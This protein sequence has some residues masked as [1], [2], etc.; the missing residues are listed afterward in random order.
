MQ[1]LL[2]HSKKTFLLAYPVVLSQLGHILVG[3][4]DSAMVG[5]LG[6]APLAAVSLGNSLFSIVL[7]MGIGLS[8]GLTPLV[9]AA[10]GRKDVAENGRLLRHGNVLLTGAGLVLCGLLWFAVPG[11]HF[12]RQPEAV[13][14][15]TIPYLRVLLFS[16]I[17]LMAF[18]ALRQF[19]EG[20]SFTRQAMYISVSANLVNILGNWLLINGHWGLPALG[21][22]GAGLSTLFSR[23]LMALGMAVYI[24]YSRRFAPYRQHQHWSRFSGPVFR[25]IL[26]LGIPISL[27]MVFEISAFSVA[28]LMVGWLGTYELAAHQ[29]AISLAAVTYMM[30]SGISTAATI[31]VGNQW[32]LRNGPEL[33]GVGLSAF[34]MVILF[35]ASMAAV[36][37]LGRDVLTSLYTPDRQVVDIAVQLLIIAA[38]FQLSDGVQVVALG[39]LRGMSDV[40]VPTLITLLAY[41]VI[42]LPV[43][44]VLG[45]GLDLGVSGIWYGL[46]TGLTVAA[47]L[48]TLRF[49]RISRTIFATPGRPAPRPQESA[50]PAP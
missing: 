3:V 20:L 15:L 12:L 39:A 14:A 28:A 5:Q 36:F 16:L 44:Y 4:A 17:P 21:L 22:Y 33:R 30:A 2:Q 47:I 10:D 9:A 19:A 23:I 25:E 8:F 35:M 29:I 13:V 7:V 46:L 34:V 49:Y 42:G 31:R 38:F 27:Q 26:R 40:R 18:Q 43:G 32:G 11:L 6:A 1:T 50:I 48:L 41:W 37:I 45:M 24:F